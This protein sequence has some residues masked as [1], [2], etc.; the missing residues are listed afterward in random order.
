MSS[1]E[2]VTSS[3][4]PSGANVT[5]VPNKKSN[6]NDVKST[7]CKSARREGEGEGGYIKPTRDYDSLC[8]LHKN[9][10]EKKWEIEDPRIQQFMAGC[11]DKFDI[12]GGTGHGH[13]SRFQ[14]S[15]GR[16]GVR[17]TKR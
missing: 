1:V 13:T 6:D 11:E 4:S 12:M 8:A 5:V 14:W 7:H 2:R 15:R 3:S 9:N 16:S 10:N 17:D